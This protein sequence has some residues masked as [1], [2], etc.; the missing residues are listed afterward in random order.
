[1]LQCDFLQDNVLNS[2]MAAIPSTSSQEL[3]V[4]PRA[5]SGGLA[6][7]SA[8]SEGTVGQGLCPS[9]SSSKVAS[10]KKQYPSHHPSRERESRSKFHQKSRY[11]KE[12]RVPTSENKPHT[13]HKPKPD[14]E[15]E[16]ADVGTLTDPP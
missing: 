14:R 2:A 12:R 13:S 1:M 7:S 4:H 6:S 11:H 8:G 16:P 3:Y 9:S 10:G 15:R 5:R